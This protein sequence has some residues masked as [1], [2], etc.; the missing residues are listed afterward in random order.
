MT[1]VHVTNN[2]IFP[3]TPSPERK[4]E[5]TLVFSEKQIELIEDFT[6]WM[7]Q[8]KKRE[9]SMETISP[10]KHACIIAP[11]HFNAESC[12]IIPLSTPKT[13]DL[14]GLYLPPSTPSR[15]DVLIQAA[16]VYEKYVTNQTTSDITFNIPDARAM[17]Y[18]S[19]TT[20][21]KKEE[22]DALKNDDLMQNKETRSYSTL[23]SSRPWRPW[24]T[25]TMETMVHEYCTKS[26]V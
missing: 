2:I 23:Q 14:G 6:E 21:E 19:T 24:Y 20:N 5:Y 25:N 11:Q 4:L 22:E 13:R 26:T 15:L 9:P 17:D 3:L 10:R 16:D 18:S 1:H 12:E 8:S 7:Y